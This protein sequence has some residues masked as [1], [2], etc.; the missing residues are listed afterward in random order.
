MKCLVCHASWSDAAGT[1]CPQC[2]HDTS[3]AGATDPARILAAR[4]SFQDKTTAFAPHTRVSSLDKW[5]PWLALVLALLLF[6]FWV[7]TCFG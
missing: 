4:A 7:K 3:A 6:A 2:G 1:T 5:K